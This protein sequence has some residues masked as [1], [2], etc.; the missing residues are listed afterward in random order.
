MTASSEADASAQAPEA[1]QRV[2]CIRYPVRFQEGQAIRALIDF[3]SEV[4]AMTPAYA[5][6]LGLTTRNTSV[7]AEKIDGLPLETYS[8]VSASFSLQ[9]SLGRV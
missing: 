6:E 7:G 3:G 5:T 1:L 4:N 8:M 2:S 9:N